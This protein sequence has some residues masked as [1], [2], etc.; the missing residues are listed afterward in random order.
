MRPP[1]PRPSGEALYVKTSR[2]KRRA[3]GAEAG[4]GEVAGSRKGQRRRGLR[5]RPQVDVGL[6]SSCPRAPAAC[7][8]PGL[9]WMTALCCSQYP[10]AVGKNTLL[11]AGLQ[12][13]NNAR[14]VFSGSLDFFSD[15]FFNSAVQKA[16]PGSQRWVLAGSGAC[17]LVLGRKEPSS[18]KRRRPGVFGLKTLLLCW[19]P[20]LFKVAAAY[21]EM[22]QRVCLL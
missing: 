13:R 14:V 8:F 4:E 5:C 17:G 20:R 12:A 21:P 15:A 2:S 7:P 10:H 19:Y 1:G 3:H 11:I 22:F 6:L 18:W 9:S 16:A